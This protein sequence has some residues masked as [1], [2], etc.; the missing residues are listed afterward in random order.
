MLTTTLAL[1]LGF[2]VFAFSELDSLQL[3]GLLTAYTLLICLATDLTFLPTI[4]METGLVTVWDYVGLR[5]NKQ[6]VQRLA[7]FRGLS[8][9]EAKIATLLAYSEDLKN[10]QV[11]F[12][13]G[14]QGLSLIHI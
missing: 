11:L 4:V 6:L 3:F 8:V 2:S 12:K 10:R 13:T 5:I 1:G 7:I 9:R 14:D